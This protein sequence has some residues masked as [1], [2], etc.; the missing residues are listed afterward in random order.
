MAGVQHAKQLLLEC[1]S[2][3]RRIHWNRFGIF[4]RLALFANLCT[5]LAGCLHNFLFEGLRCVRILIR[6]VFP[7]S[8]V[9]AFTYTRALCAGLEALAVLFQAFRFFA[10]A[11]FAH[12]LGILLALGKGGIFAP[13]KSVRILVFTVLNR[14]FAYFF[15]LF[16]VV[17][18]GAVATLAIDLPSEAFA[19]KLEAFRL[20]AVAGF[21][22]CING[23]S[24][25]RGTA[26]SRPSSGS[27][28]VW[29]FL[30]LMGAF[31]SILLA[32]CRQGVISRMTIAL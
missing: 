31:W 22:H 8:T 24:R 32:V 11:A 2:C 18:V 27:R 6:T 14:C 15:E 3:S 13:K 16:N 21:F 23:I 25:F 30:V 9:D 5:W 12:R 26:S 29:L 17:T 10:V 4:G 20:L 7:V 1:N 28:S 19:V